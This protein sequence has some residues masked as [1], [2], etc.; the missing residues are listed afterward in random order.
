MALLLSVERS[1]WFLQLVDVGD[2]WED[3]IDA[4]VDAFEKDTGKLLLHTVLFY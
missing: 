3:N 1:S 4:M 2:E